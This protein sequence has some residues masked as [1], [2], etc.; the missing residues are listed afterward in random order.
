MSRWSKPVLDAYLAGVW[1]VFWTEDTL[2]WIAKPIVATET[3]G[4]G[5]RRLHHETLGAVQSDLENLYFLNGVSV[6]AFVVVRPDWI[7]LQH[8]KSESNEEVRRI[9]IE[10]YGWTRYLA[11]MGAVVI[12]SRR[13]DVECTREALM[14]LAETK[15]LVCHCP[16]TARIYAM[17]VDPRISSA[18]EA[19]SYLWSGSRL[20][21]RQKLNIIG[22]S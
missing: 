12:D 21:Q 15:V 11:D 4:D 3:T 16:S 5:Q 20:A 2:Y 7:T 9:M 8:I 22:R 14:Q 17:E 6:P 1:F 10:R 13:N 19:Q 18:E